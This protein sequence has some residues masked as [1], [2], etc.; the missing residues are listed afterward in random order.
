MGLD[1]GM[2]VPI[3]FVA[4]IDPRISLKG[5]SPVIEVVDT[6]VTVVVS[7]TLAL[8]GVVSIDVAEEGRY[9]CCLSF[10]GC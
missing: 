10:K 5:I 7:P 9:C 3:I 8:I 4:A 2:V 1:V 6:A